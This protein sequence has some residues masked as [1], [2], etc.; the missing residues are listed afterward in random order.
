MLETILHGKKKRFG[1]IKGICCTDK[2]IA[3]AASSEQCVRICKIPA[4]EKTS[5]VQQISLLNM[6]PSAIALSNDT[7]YLAVG[8]H[9]N[10]SI[11]LFALNIDK[12][13][14]DEPFAKMIVEKF[15]PE[16]KNDVERLHFVGN[17]FLIS[18]TSGKLPI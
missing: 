5:Q 7:S 10:N 16:H 9:F 13:K 17:Q 3:F 8:I 14:K 12:S 4:F 18:S 15:N 11:R 1:S 2:A 6:T